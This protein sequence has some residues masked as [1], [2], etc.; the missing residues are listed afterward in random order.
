MGADDVIIEDLY[1][2]F[3]SLSAYDFE[4]TEMPN[5]LYPYIAFVVSNNDKAYNAVKGKLDRWTEKKYKSIYE[6]CVWRKCRFVTRLLDID[7]EIKIINVLVF[8]CSE[9]SKKE[10]REV[11][12]EGW[13]RIELY[14]R[15]AEVIDFN[16]APIRH[17]VEEKWVLCFLAY[18]DNKIISQARD[19][20]QW[21]EITSELFFSSEYIIQ[22]IEND[23]V[24]NISNLM[25][26]DRSMPVYVDD[27]ASCFKE[28]DVADFQWKWVYYKERYID[29]L[30]L[31]KLD[32][33]ISENIKENHVV[34]QS[35]NQSDK[36]KYKKSIHFLKDKIAEL[37]SKN[38][39][40]YNR[41]VELSNLVDLLYEE[42]SML[43]V[44]EED[45]TDY[46]N[47]E[48]EEG[49]D[50]N[51]MHS[52]KI[53]ICGG[54]FE[55]QR[56]MSAV[57]PEWKYINNNNVRFDEQ[58]V[59]SN[60][61]EAIIFNSQYVSHGFFYRLASK[62]NRDTP[63]LYINTSSVEYGIKMIWLKLRELQG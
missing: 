2:F 46:I 36:D 13:K 5:S 18:I 3:N 17:K 39:C 20:K 63:I 32:K 53:V 24:S 19:R 7:K 29:M 23:P 43:R 54:R 27:E 4:R 6:K 62:K 16:E 55:W 42:I 38:S 12:S 49:I 60:E 52:K 30:L 15:N 9:M 51:Y 61:I 1:K 35:E 28:T 37:K 59:K 11:I 8:L 40:L 58:I 50:W 41:N 44:S 45:N 57:F 25:Y 31:S 22:R 33:D 48:N 26:W 14:V 21:Y 56:K 47:E 10:L 34:F